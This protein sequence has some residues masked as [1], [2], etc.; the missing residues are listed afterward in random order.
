M[1][2]E[3]EFFIADRRCRKLVCKFHYY[4]ID[5]SGRFR[6]LCG[7]IFSAT[8]F[9]LKTESAFQACDRDQHDFDP[10]W[11]SGYFPV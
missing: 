4:D 11:H 1:G 2:L 3:A 10:G 6:L 8:D 7:A 5:R 9:I